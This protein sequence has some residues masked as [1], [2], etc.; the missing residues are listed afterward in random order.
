MTKRDEPTA[1]AILADRAALRRANRDLLW[2]DHGILRTFW[3]NFAPVAPQVYRSNHPPSARLDVYSDL[4]IRAIINLRGEPKKP[5]QM[6]EAER[7]AELG[8]AFHSIALNARQA[9]APR[10]LLELFGLFDT[11]ARPFLLHCKSGADRAGLAAALYLL[12]QGESVATA[13]RQLSWRYLHLA[14]TRTGIQDMFLDMYA[15]RL[16]E[17]EITIRDWIANE[18]DRDDLIARFGRKWILPL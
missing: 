8:I 9:P 13:R 14:F 15:E 5:F 18:Y 12:D 10:R 4:G 1:S 2:R 6:I 17:G 7:C 3:T 16:A 11:V